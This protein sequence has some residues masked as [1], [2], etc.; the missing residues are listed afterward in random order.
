MAR[1]RI[2][3]SCGDGYTNYIVNG[4]PKL[5]FERCDQLCEALGSNV[6]GYEDLGHTKLN[7]T[8]LKTVRDRSINVSKDHKEDVRRMNLA[9]EMAMS[10]KNR[11][12]HFTGSEVWSSDCPIRWRC[13]HQRSSMPEHH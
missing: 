12:Q 2:D 13:P 5:R 4:R 6:P 3:Y 9:L 11:K 8:R 7:L 1:Q 10:P